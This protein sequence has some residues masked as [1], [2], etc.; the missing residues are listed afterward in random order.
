MK[1]KK[2]PRTK[3]KR[4]DGWLTELVS[5]HHADDPFKGI[6]TYLVCIRPGQ[7]R[8][9]HYHEKKEEWLAVTHGRVRLD[10]EDIET[11]E[12]ET[13]LLDAESDDYHIT[14]IPPRV[15]HAITNPGRDDA[16]LVVFAKD[17]AL[18]DTLHYILEL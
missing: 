2:L 10:L 16:S 15:A 7:T 8:A 6:H 11:K 13:L 3:H 1:H 9:C 14:Y 4:E 18:E 12:K 5:G 17:R